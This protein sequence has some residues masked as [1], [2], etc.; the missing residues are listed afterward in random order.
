MTPFTEAVVA[1]NDYHFISRWRVRGTCEEVYEILQDAKGLPRWWPSVYLDALEIQS[2]GPERKDMVVRVQ[3]KGWLPVKLNWHFAV[4]DS[5]PPRGF[6]LKAWGDLE[7][8]GRWTLSQD[9]DFVDVTYDWRVR[10]RKPV[11]RYTSA[12]FRPL[13]SHSHHWAMRKGEESLRLELE[14]RRAK[15]AAERARV[16]PAPGPAP[17]PPAPLVMG[18]GLLVAWLLLGRAG[19]RRRQPRRSRA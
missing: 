7:G 19:R 9:G 12:F 16:P 11:L 10:G 2:G 17:S 18:I 4:T 15:S 8:T 5:D 1:A 6:G 3:A 14:R 13:F